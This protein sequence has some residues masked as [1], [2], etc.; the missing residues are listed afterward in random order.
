[1]KCFALVQSRLEPI[2][3]LNLPIMLF[4]NASKFPLLCFKFSLLCFK[5]SLLC[6]VVAVFC[7]IF[8]L[9]MLLICTCLE[10]CWCCLKV[11]FDGSSEEFIISIT[12]LVCS[13]HHFVAHAHCYAYCITSLRGNCTYYAS[14]MLNALVFLKCQKLC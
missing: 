7:M 11:K 4:G 2:M 12:S 14:I 10:Y 6:Q 1:M 3:L 8:K 13:R 9:K 5:I